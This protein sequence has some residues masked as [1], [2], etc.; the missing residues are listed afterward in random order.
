MAKHVLVTG[1]T[2]FTGGFVVKALLGA[3]YRVTC[4]VRNLQKAE[5][6]LPLEAL[7][8]I[9]G[10]LEDSEGLSF[11]LGGKDALVNVASVGF[12]HGPGI[13]KACQRSGVTRAV[14]FSSTALFTTLEAKTKVVRQTAEDAIK[15]SGLDFTI[16][17]PTMI[18]GTPDDRNMIR[19]IRFLDRFPVIPVFG[20]GQ[21]LQQPVYVE[22]LAD[23]V[24][25][26]LE[27]QSS[28][29]KAYNLSGKAPV[30]YN[31]VIDTTAELLEKKITKLHIPVGFS[32]MVAK[33]LSRI[34]S[35]PSITKEQVMR[36]NEN[37]AFDHS[38]GNADFGYKP[39]SFRE[40]IALEIT[41]YRSDKKTIK[42]ISGKRG[43]NRIWQQKNT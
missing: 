32:I 43:K 16:I 22:D 1:A 17:R 11:A 27:N 2:G 15:T 9:P 21:S 30:T 23:S 34:P 33:T 14:F 29:G 3:G 6:K 39:R 37:K 31:E 4:Y 7:E 19:L 5:E 38:E 41:Q 18:Y 10:N 42:E 28:V 26:I 35:F 13:V 12:G 36:L 20:S 24:A 40:G 8:L 25:R